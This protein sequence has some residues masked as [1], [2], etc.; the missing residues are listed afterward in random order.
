MAARLA[1]KS[2]VLDDDKE[3]TKLLADKTK[4]AEPVVAKPKVR[5]S[6]VGQYIS[7]LTLTTAGLGGM[8][9]NLG[10]KFTAESRDKLVIFPHDRKKE[11]EDEDGDEIIGSGMSLVNY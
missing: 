6:K 5:K 9:S 11:D 3:D 2:K 10:L 1:P 7:F 8:K 4:L